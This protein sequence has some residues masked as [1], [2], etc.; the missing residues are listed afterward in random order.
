MK[1]VLSGMSDDKAT[2]QLL[3]GDS[4]INQNSIEQIP[5]NNIIKRGGAKMNNF[6]ETERL[7]M[8]T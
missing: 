6:E 8:N 1:G 7:L 3:K 5:N 4:F 2:D